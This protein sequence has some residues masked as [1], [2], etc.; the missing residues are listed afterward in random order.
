MLKSIAVEKVLVSFMFI[1]LLNSIQSLVVD[2]RNKSIF[3]V[4]SANIRY[5]QLSSGF[6][7]LNQLYFIN[8]HSLATR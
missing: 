3:Y 6:A 2:F 4:S 8:L 7:S 5:L 1:L